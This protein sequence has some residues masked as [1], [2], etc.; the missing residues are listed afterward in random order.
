MSKTTLASLKVDSKKY[1]LISILRSEFVDNPRIRAVLE[2]EPE[3]IFRAVRVAEA[4]GIVQAVP[5]IPMPPLATKKDV[6]IEPTVARASLVPQPAHQPENIIYGDSQ[7][8]RL[9][10][11][12]KPWRKMEFKGSSCSKILNGAR[13]SMAK[14]TKCALQ[15]WGTAHILKGG[16]AQQVLSNTKEAFKLLP[17][18][19]KLVLGVPEL[20]PGKEEVA[21]KTNQLL[22][23]LSGATFI[24]FQTS[25]LGNDKTHLTNEEA[26][27]LCSMVPE[28]EECLVSM[29]NQALPPQDLPEFTSPSKSVMADETTMEVQG[30]RRKKNMNP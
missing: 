15:M 8:G 24:P 17:N 1:M 18:A 6:A 21:A 10:K 14:S 9:P 23:E 4:L 28:L 7:V 30:K 19:K 25:W 22:A 13:G 3:L 2:E 11:L 5:K 27:E 16:T 20:L 26:R 12:R 29:T